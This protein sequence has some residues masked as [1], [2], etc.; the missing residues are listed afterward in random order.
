VLLY[1]P[2]TLLHD[3][4]SRQGQDVMAGGRALSAA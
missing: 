4:F 1:S 3:V 2:V